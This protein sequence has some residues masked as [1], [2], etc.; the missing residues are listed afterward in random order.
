M[1]VDI[2]L[3][4]STGVHGIYGPLGDGLIVGTT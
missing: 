4:N 3:I 2:L 1:T